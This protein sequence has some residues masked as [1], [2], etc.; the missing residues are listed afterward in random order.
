MN[1]M[2][3]SRKDVAAAFRAAGCIDAD[4]VIFH[5]SLKSMGYVEGGAVA[6]Y[7][8]ILDAVGINGTVAVPSLWY[9][10]KPQERKKEDFDVKSSPAYN[11]TIPEALRLDPRAYRSDN[12]S[13]AVCAI[14]AR[15]AELTGNHGKGKLYPAPWGD[16]AFAEISPWSKLYEWN[17]LYCFIGVDMNTCTIK[18]YIESRF[19]EDMLQK[20]PP[21]KYDDFRR[22]LAHDCCGSILPWAYYPGIKM[23]SELEARNLITKVKLGSAEVMA[24]RTRPLVDTTTEILRSAPQEWFTTDF[25]SW[26]QRVNTAANHS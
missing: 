26:M 4:T 13:H 6:V 11:G 14:G 5:S 8:G 12:F 25:C 20:L 21:E 17:A 15:A 10:G 1:K 9:N 24:L 3:V 22:E 7:N 2:Q 19:V 23:R 16:E 18:H